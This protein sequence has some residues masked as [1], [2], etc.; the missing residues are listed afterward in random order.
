MRR[1]DTLGTG[2]WCTES[3]GLPGTRPRHLGRDES[4]SP[5]VLEYSVSGTKEE[6]YLTLSPPTQFLPVTDQCFGS[7][8]VP[9]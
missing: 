5:E 2:Y 9:V 3:G 1:E 8:D 6:P 7:L 4:T